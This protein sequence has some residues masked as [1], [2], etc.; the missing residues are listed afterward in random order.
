MSDVVRTLSADRLDGVERDDDPTPI[1]GAAWYVGTNVDDGLEYRFEPGAL[2]GGTHLATDVLL[3][4]DSLVRFRLTLQEGAEG[5]TFHLTYGL[6]NQCSARVR[7]PLTAV[8]QNRWK[9]PREG[10]WLKPLAEGERVNLERVDRIAIRIDRKSD[11]PSRWCQTPIRVTDGEPPRLSEPELPQGPLLDEL[12]QSTLHEWDGRT[13]SIETATDRIQRQLKRTN[14]CDKSEEYSQWDGWTEQ[15]FEATGFFRTHYDGDRWWLVDPDG[16]PFWSSGVDCVSVNPET[17]TDGL[18]DA[19]SWVPD[20]DGRFADAVGEHNGLPTVNYLCANLI[21][22][23]GPDDW[24]NRWSD[25]ALSCLR[26]AGFNTVGNWS[27]WEIA[28]DAGMP[29]V[30]PLEFAFGGINDIYRDFPDVFDPGFPEAAAAYASQLEDT[31]DDPAL[32][33]YFLQNEPTWAFADET[34]AAGMLYTTE[35]CA[36]RDRLVSYLKETYGTADALGDAWEMAVD[37]ED[38]ES[39][40]WTRQLTNAARDDLRKFSEKLVDRLYDIVS[41]ACRTVDPN[42]LNL[43]VRYPYVPDD[44]ALTGMRHVDVFSINCYNARVDDYAAVAEK[45]DIPVLVG[46]WHFGALDVGLPATGIGHVPNQDARGDAFRV[47][48]E[49]AAAKPWCIGVHYFTLYDQSALGRFDGEN[50]NIGFYDICHR[51]YEP[52]VDAARRS[53]ERLYDVAVGDELPFDN[54]PTYLPKLF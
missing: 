16:H 21:R 15:Q 30:R 46:E 42:H 33:G 29:Y 12:G 38:V 7:M 17:V 22:A 4:G 28:R 31:V 43:G 3:D 32:L 34:P 6:L 39:G 11:T 27:D 40:R 13:S 36:T 9:F 23:F 45:F 8:D 37:F 51:S 5:P 24:Y 18:D 47:Y 1:E 10:A 20:P 25:L 41:D 49:D 2:A 54:E 53:H 50:Y 19:L 14:E 44:W 35:N 26:D 48:L 52:L